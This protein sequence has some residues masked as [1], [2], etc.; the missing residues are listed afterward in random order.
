[1]PSDDW[2]MG[3]AVPLFISKKSSDCLGISANNIEN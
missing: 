3:F 2:E 1:M